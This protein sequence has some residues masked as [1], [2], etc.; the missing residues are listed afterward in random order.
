[1]L[2]LPAA[3][4]HEEGLPSETRIPGFGDSIVS[5]SY[6]TGADTTCSPTSQYRPKEPV[7]VP[8]Y[9]T[10]TSCYIDRLEGPYYEPRQRTGSTGKDVKDSGAC[11]AVTSPVEPV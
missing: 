2:P 4:T 9:C 5:V 1:M 6:G 10:S 7:S 3:R 11:L 8:R